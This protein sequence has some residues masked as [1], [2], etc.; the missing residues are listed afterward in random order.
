MVDH[1]FAAQFGLISRAEAR[2]EGLSPR[3][4]H[5]RLERGEWI[6]EQSGVFRHAAVPRTW[7]SELLAACM[8]TGGVASHRSASVLWGL[9]PIRRAV[10]EIQVSVRS[11]PRIDRVIVHRSKQWDRIDANSIRGIPV[12]GINRTLLDCGAVVTLRTL[13][14]MVESAIRRRLT[15]W[16]DLHAALVR[17][18]RKGRDGCGPL[19]DL[20][21]IRMGRG[22]VPLSDFSRVVFNLLTDHGI[23][24]PEV[25]YR[26]LGADGGFIMQ[27]DLAWPAQRKAWELDGLAFHFG[28]LERERDNRKRNRA[29]AEGW[30]IQEILWSMFV[31]DPD[32]LV[33]T[34]RRFLAA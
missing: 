32:A 10:P 17:H 21:E 34:C 25:E 14:R 7:E 18:S 19:R 11:A 15:S 2:A 31:D 5:L 30:N 22:T 4:I 27:T 33:E 8:S 6:R 28:R 9:D 13:E 3:Q 16:A 26:I 1:I 20:L 24:P 29:K 23:D 12:T